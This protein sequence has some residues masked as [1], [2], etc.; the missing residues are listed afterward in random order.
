VFDDGALVNAIDENM[1]L[2]SKGRL[3]ALTPSKKILRMADGRCVPS[4]GVCRDCH[5]YT[6]PAGKC[7]GLAWGKRTGWRFVPL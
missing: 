6:I 2:T 7:H 4:I 3:T 1:Y 5:G